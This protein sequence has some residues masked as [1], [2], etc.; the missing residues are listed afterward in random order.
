MTITGFMLA[1]NVK[2]L[3]NTLAYY[4]YLYTNLSRSA[5]A[6]CIN[7]YRLLRLDFQL[8][9]A[10]CG[11]DFQL[12]A[13]RN[14]LRTNRK[15]RHFYFNGLQELLAAPL[16]WVL[17][18]GCT[19]P[20]HIVIYLIIILFIHAVFP[21]SSILFF[22]VFIWKRL[23]LS[24]FPNKIPLSLSSTCLLEFRLESDVERSQIKPADSGRH[25]SPSK[26]K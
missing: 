22:Y 11:L 15:T 13:F 16:A 2:I 10:S 3:S 18:L 24:Y 6:A 21:R 9:E 17:Y 8:P 14:F 19:V 26:Y 5:T 20:C 1:D 23:S 12:L 25:L 7:I 4:A